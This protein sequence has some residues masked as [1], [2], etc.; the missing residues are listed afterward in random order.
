MCFFLVGCLD[1]S[2]NNQKQPAYSLVEY[3]DWCGDQ[4][5]GEWKYSKNTQGNIVANLKDDG[6][7]TKMNLLEPT[8]E[9]AIVDYALVMATD[10]SKQIEYTDDLAVGE[11]IIYAL[12]NKGISEGIIEG[13]KYSVRASLPLDDTDAEIEKQIFDN[14]FEYYIASYES[15]KKGFYY[16]DVN[17]FFNNLDIRLLYTYHESKKNYVNSDIVKTMNSVFKE[18]ECQKN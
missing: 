1:G 4:K 13:Q 17:C 7:I 10:A 16:K 8:S 3:L 5:V 6:W 9:E 18:F 15:N 2:S 12:N 11:L 14:G